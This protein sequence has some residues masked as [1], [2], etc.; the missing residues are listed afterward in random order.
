MLRALV[1]GLLAV[2]VLAKGLP[3]QQGLGKLAIVTNFAGRDARYKAVKK[4]AQARG[5]KIFRFAEGKLNTVRGKLKSAGVEFVAVAVTPATIDINFHYDVLEL[6]RNLDDDPMPDFSFGYLTAR[7][8]AD[9]ESMVDRILAREAR[10]ADAPVAKVI[11]LTGTGAQLD[12]L[13]F[14][15]HFGHGQAW[16]VDKGMTG[17]EVGKLELKR[18]PVVWS[19]ACFNGVFSRSYH[20]CAYQPIFMPPT[21]IKPEHVMTLNWVHAG[22]SGYFAAL[23][24]DR[25]EMAIAEWDYFRERACSLGE[26]M[27]YQYRLAFTSLPEDFAGFPRYVPNRKKRMWFYDVMLRGMVS[28]L[29]LSDPSYRPLRKPLTAP[30]HK[31]AVGT[32]D[33]TLTVTIELLRWTQGHH[34]N[35]LPK[36]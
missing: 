26:V 29:L 13:D 22:V 10:P 1:V 28:R 21:A 8:G 16:R 31:T 36:S 18:A 15:L 14:A 23:E 12:G 2:P 33:K 3:K 19:G 32:K 24:G 35:Y 6:C 5:A 25:G 27:T 4:L 11:A 17:T 34:L 9:L 30:V 7:S 20:K